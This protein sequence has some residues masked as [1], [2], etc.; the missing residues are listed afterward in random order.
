VS[1]LAAIVGRVHRASRA[2]H[3]FDVIVLPHP[4]G[5]STWTNKPG[6][7]ALLERSLGLIR[8]AMRTAGVPA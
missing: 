4:S 7:R 6:N 2:G 1:E 5:R 3:E 8:K